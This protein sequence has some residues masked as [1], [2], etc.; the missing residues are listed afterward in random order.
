[1]PKLSLFLF[2]LLDAGR[3]GR[4]HLNY[5]L[6]AGLSPLP[7]IYISEDCAMHHSTSYATSVPGAGTWKETHPGQHAPGRQHL[8]VLLSILTAAGAAGVA[9]WHYLN[10]WMSI[11][12]L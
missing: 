5:L 11:P 10:S 3:G 2:A 8:V 1:M 12:L 9:I 6:A 7:G 4:C